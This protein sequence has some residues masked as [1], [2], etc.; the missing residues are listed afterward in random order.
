MPPAV[1]VASPVRKSRRE[2]VGRGFSP[3]DVTAQQNLCNL[4]N[5]WFLSRLSR[6]E[7]GVG[8]GFALGSP[9]GGGAAS[10]VAGGPSSSVRIGFR[11]SAHT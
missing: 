1:S 7:L 2:A 4:W 10:V 3:A 5:L 11:P 6:Y 8:F 9:V